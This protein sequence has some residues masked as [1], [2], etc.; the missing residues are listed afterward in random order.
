MNFL[1]AHKI[2]YEYAGIFASDYH[3]EET[4]L[5]YPMSKV[6]FKGSLWRDD[7]I[8]A[9][10]IVFSHAILWKDRSPEMIDRMICLLKNLNCFAYDPFC[11]EIRK[12]YNIMKKKGTF[13]GSIH[14]NRVIEA[15]KCYIST[16]IPTSPYRIN[17]VYET[18]NH[19]LAYKS[20]TFDKN[21]ENA[22]LI[23]K[24]LSFH[25]FAELVFA[26]CKEAYSFSNITFKETDAN[27]FFS[28]DLMKKW[29]HDSN[30]KKFFAGYEDY[31]S[32][33]R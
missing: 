22:N 8:S 9:H 17:D 12:N 11:D 10:Q 18:Y 26:Y 3:A 5:Y 25:D 31:I 29:I 1:D 27:F 13:W 7:V 6:P 21:I 28:F 32:D 14:K 15:E 33:N 24:Q 30:Y 19:M 4:A 23:G 20:N 2:C 16:P